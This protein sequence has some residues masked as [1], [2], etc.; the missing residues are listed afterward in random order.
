LQE[1]PHQATFIN[2]LKLSDFKQVIIKAGLSAEFSGGVLWCCNSTVA[3]RKVR[4]FDKLVE[5]A[6]IKLI[7][8][9]LE[10][11]AVTIEG[12]LSPEYYQL[13]E[14]LYSQYAIV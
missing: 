13:R 11:G 9:Q 6:L 14:L 5:D 2:K 1:L 8:F 10:N 7:L 4:F 3:V 12:C